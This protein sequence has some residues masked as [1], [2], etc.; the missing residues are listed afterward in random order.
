MDND[1]DSLGQKVLE[2]KVSINKI[3][4]EVWKVDPNLPPL[5]ES[6]PEDVGVVFTA[7]EFGKLSYKEFLE[8]LGMSNE[9]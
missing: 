1:T 3:S 4:E 6:F 8:K 5:G 9:V 7:E 2:S